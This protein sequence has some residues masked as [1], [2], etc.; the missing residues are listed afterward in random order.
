MPAS[1]FGFN[2]RNLFP[3]FRMVDAAKL[4]QNLPEI[5][6]QFFEN[7]PPYHAWRVD[8]V[9]R[10]QICEIP[11]VII[12]RAGTIPASK[13]ISLAV[14]LDKRKFKPDRRDSINS[15]VSSDQRRRRNDVPL[16]GEGPQF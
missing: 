15:A 6:D 14:L 4:R 3:A 8:R 16:K 7:T 10:S 1:S 5:G 2:W 12:E 9:V 13:I 11:H